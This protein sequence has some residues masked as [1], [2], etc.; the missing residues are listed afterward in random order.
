VEKPSEH[1]EKRSSRTPT[2]HG[3]TRPL[4]PQCEVLRPLARRG[5]RERLT[6]PSAAAAVHVG[7]DVL[8]ALVRDHRQ[9]DGDA[10]LAAGAGSYM[11][12]S[13]LMS[14]G[15]RAVGTSS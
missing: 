2:C 10:Q 15:P 11:T 1:S 4:S 7:D 12:S 3:Q 8:E 6:R 9:A 5:W 13:L 14:A